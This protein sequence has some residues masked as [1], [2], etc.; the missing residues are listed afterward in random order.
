MKNK[1]T[2][3]KTK[4][5]GLVLLSFMVIYSLQGIYKNIDHPNDWRFYCVAL[6]FIFFSTFLAVAIFKNSKS[7]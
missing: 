1:S 2:I 7:Q 3:T 4:I 5:S 6:S